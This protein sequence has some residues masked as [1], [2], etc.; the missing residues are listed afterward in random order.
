MLDL[1]VDGDVGEDSL[2]AFVLIPPSLL[3]MEPNKLRDMMVGEC[4]CFE[5]WQR[6]TGELLKDQDGEGE[7]VEVILRRR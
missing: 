6:E 2:S 4:W 7:S 1:P 5:W 3:L